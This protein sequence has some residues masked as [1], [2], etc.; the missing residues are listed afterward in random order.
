ME[1]LI[2]YHETFRRRDE[3]GAIARGLKD[4]YPQYD[5]DKF[6]LLKQTSSVCR[7]DKFL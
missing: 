7:M 5:F 4:Q 1:G 2:S 6:T 3:E